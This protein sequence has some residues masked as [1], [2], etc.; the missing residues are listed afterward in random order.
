M[1]IKKLFIANRKMFM[2]MIVYGAIYLSYKKTYND[3]E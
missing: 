1:V 3:K 2:F